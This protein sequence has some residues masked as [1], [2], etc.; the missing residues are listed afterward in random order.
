[1]IYVSRAATGSRDLLPK[2]HI[3]RIKL[4][5]R[6]TSTIRSRSD[7]VLW[8]IQSIV[9]G[10]NLT[11]ASPRQTSI[12]YVLHCRGR[13]RPAQGKFHI[14]ASYTANINSRSPV[15]Q[16]YSH[17]YKF[18]SAHCSQPPP[19]PSHPTPPHLLLQFHRAP[20]SHIQITHGSKQDKK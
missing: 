13:R 7:P 14:L 17:I 15:Y 9:S 2:S 5:R 20:P 16:M 3:L 10:L 6:T 8:E 12:N 11:Q 1:M 18:P 4:H 19:I